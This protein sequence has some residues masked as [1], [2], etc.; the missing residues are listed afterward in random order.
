M[1]TQNIIYLNFTYQCSCDIAITILQTSRTYETITQLTLPIPS[2]NTAD[3]ELQ[4]ETND[5]Q[6]GGFFS[7]GKAWI[8]SQLSTLSERIQGHIST[9]RSVDQVTIHDCLGA[10][11]DEKNTTEPNW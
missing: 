9:R 8:R 4:H 7:S 10:F 3:M 5:Q 1:H 6:G 2:V 11:I